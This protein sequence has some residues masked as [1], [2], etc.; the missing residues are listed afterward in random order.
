MVT[1]K[2]HT[3]FRSFDGTELILNTGGILRLFNKAPRATFFHLRDTLGSVFGS[4]RREWLKRNELTFKKKRTANKLFFYRMRP[5]DRDKM[6]APG[7]TVSLDKISGETFTRSKMALAH[8]LGGTIRPTS[9]RFLSIPIGGALTPGGSVRRG[10]RDPREFRATFP[11][12]NLVS[13]ARD[14][15]PVLYEAKKGRGQTEKLVP[16]FALLRS[17]TLKQRLNFMSTWD[18]LQADRQRRFD[19]MLRR[20][21]KDVTDG[22]ST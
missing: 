17:V 20:I 14:G 12:R 2:D 3:T 18:S 21:V 22:K 15:K 11:N 5:A 8:E 9:G 16:M 13:L 6:P 7:A 4:Q 1:F 10:M 19:E